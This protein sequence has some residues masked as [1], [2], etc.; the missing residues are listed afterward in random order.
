M[1]D[2]SLLAR[3]RLEDHN[4]HVWW[5]RRFAPADTLLETNYPLADSAVVFFDFPEVHLFGTVA[6]VLIL[7]ARGRIG[8]EDNIL[9]TSAEPQR[10]FAP[11]VM[12]K[13]FAWSPKAKSRC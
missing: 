5:I 1:G 11:S 2:D 9:Y 7:G 4:L 13:S 8:L 6:S 10:G 12:L 3:V